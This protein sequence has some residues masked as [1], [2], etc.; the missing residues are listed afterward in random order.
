MYQ[1]P[2]S[3]QAT[4]AQACSYLSMAHNDNTHVYS[5]QEHW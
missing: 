4:K 3:V 2:F 5:S 1:L